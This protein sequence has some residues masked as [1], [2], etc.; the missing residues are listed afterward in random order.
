M[1]VLSID[2]ETYS[3]I[4]ITT[5]GAYKYVESDDFEILLFAYAFNDDPVTVI[6][7][8]DFEAVP[9]N[10]IDA[11][12]DP[13]ILKAA[14]NANFER[15]CLSKFT[16]KAVLVEQ[17]QCTAVHALTLG[18]PTNL[19]M[20]GKALKLPEDKQKLTTGKALIKYFCCPCAPTK[21]NGSR[22]RN[23]PEHAPEK[24]ELFKEYCKQDVEVERTIRGKLLR[25]PPP[26]EEHK[27]WYLDQKINDMGVQVD[28]VLVKNAIEC[29]ELYQAKLLTEAVELTGLSNPNSAAQLKKWIG[30]AEGIEVGSLTKDSTK[31][32]L[33]ETESLKVK[34]VL[35]LR[36]EM[37]KTS[38]KKYLAMERAVCKDSRIRGLLQ[39]YGA[40]RTGRWAGRLVQVQNLPQN[41]LD[42]LDLARNLLRSGDYENLELLFGS[43]PDV[44]SQLIRTAFVPTENS[45]FIVSDFSAI[46]ARVIAWLAGEKWRL[47]VFA[48]HGKIYEASASQMFKVPIESIDKHSP[49]RQKG[50]VSELALG[51]Q[52][53]P[54]A[55]EKMGA[56]SMGLTVEELPAL[57]KMW[58]NANRAIVK[59]W[60]DV[61]A[62]VIKA[63]EDKMAVRFKYGM[64]FS[65]ES[66]I[67][68]IRLPSGRRLAYARP[69]MEVEERFGKM[70]ITY[71]GMNQETKQWGKLNTYGGK[72]VE[73][74]V[75]AIARDC[76]RES[77]LRVAA[78][79]YKTAMHVHD[80]LI[81]DVPNGFGSLKQL[82]EIM[83]EPIKW[84]PGLLLRGDGYETSYYKKD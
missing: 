76:L 65:V 22:T 29:D 62:G 13:K 78:E 57:V 74:I 16:N 54:K 2:L 60:F 71:E 3:S 18:L 58:R 11:L 53:G 34:R 67:L 50:K 36:Q 63:I 30:E 46:E 24:W 75:Q 31:E 45:R 43:V 44:L 40:N 8:T 5:Q 55:L 39:F 10:V 73:N 33:K 27:I 83:A 64:V 59:L 26:P 28:Q 35:E 42:D 15:L 48:S 47:D 17:W 80:E 38:V 14:F 20:V 21:A 70:S 32:L 23:Q 12:F 6:D 4:D 37:S 79:G 49:L 82:T 51:Y 41:K 19:A 84:A 77:M 9:Q 68:F 72:L 7:L 1:D 81:V 61:E 66:G 69:R 52:G 56:L 25:F